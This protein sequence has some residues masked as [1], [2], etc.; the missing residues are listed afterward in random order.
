MG[1][2]ESSEEDTDDES[3]DEAAET[4][5]EGDE[6]K[7]GRMR[8]RSDAAF[9][10]GAAVVESGTSRARS[11]CLEVIPSVAVSLGRIALSPTF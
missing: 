10:F 3:E 4:D 11:R 2:G 1:V 5:T 9:K 6:A 7:D 8:M